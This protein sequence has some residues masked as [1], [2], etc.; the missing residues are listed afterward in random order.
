VLAVLVLSWPG[1]NTFQ[2]QHSSRVL[3]H[4]LVLHLACL[5]RALRLFMLHAGNDFNYTAAAAAAA[6]AGMM[7]HRC[8]SQTT[9]T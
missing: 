7:L 8:P 2:M 9:Q 5:T 6:A 1:A 4:L 3:R